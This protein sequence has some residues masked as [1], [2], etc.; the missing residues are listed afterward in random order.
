[1]SPISTWSRCYRRWVNLIAVI[2]LL[3]G[4]LAL[5]LAKP[6]AA[7]S[8][9]TI[10]GT[11][12]DTHG[13]PLGI[14]GV[15][16][17]Q[18][19]TYVGSGV[20][21][22]NGSYS[23]TFPSGTYTVYV[24]HNLTQYVD[25]CYDSGAPGNFTTNS[26]ACTPVDASASNVN[27]PPIAV[28][29]GYTISGTITD[30]N[31]TPLVG[32]HVGVQGSSPSPGTITAPDGT[33]SMA[34]LPGSYAVQFS[35]NGNYA[36]GCYD[37]GAP[38]NFTTN[39]SA[40]TLVAASASNVNLPAIAMPL[41]STISGKVTGPDGTTGLSGIIVGV[42]GSNPANGTRTAPDGTYSMTVLPGSYKVQF[43]DPSGT[44]ATGFYSTSGFVPS[45]HDATTLSV[46]PAATNINVS[47]P[48]VQISTGTT[49]HP[50]TPTRLLD[51][52][53]GNGL[54][55][56]LA[57]NT[58]ATFQVT[59]RGG[60]PSSATAVTGNVT[61]TGSTAGWAIYLGPDPIASPTSSTVN[62]SAG[63]VVAN[64]VTVALGS[65]GSMS[66]TYMS[67]AG[68]TTDLV[69]DVTGYF[70]PDTSGATYHAMTPTRLLDTRV[71]NGLSAKLAAN[72]PATFQ[73]SGRAGIPANATAVTGNLTVVDETSA[74]AVFLGPDPNPSPTSS[75][76]NFTTGDILANGLDVALSSG[77]TLSATYISTTG[78]TT[79]LVFDVT[80]YFTADTSGAKYVALAPARLLDTRSGNGLSGKLSANTPATFQVAGRGGVPANATAV[81]GNVTVVNETAAWAVFLG[82]DPIANPTSSTINFTT[83]DI[84][85]NGLTV[86]LSATGTLSATYMSTAGNTTDLVFDVT[87]Y[88][89]P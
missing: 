80:G 45:S 64:G 76:I 23:L 50:L 49:Y 59:G 29:L 20:V 42:Q 22:G 32:I 21:N 63:Q 11:V 65:T 69:F 2:A 44:H 14:I 67:T 52:R 68:N 58:P 66:A 4:S 89:T 71:A 27:L 25:G 9:Y 38:G 79:D 62:F 1:M 83:G 47:M 34:V 60:V 88:F 39:S 31:G 18:G 61:V 53:S 15:Y 57:A 82:P 36:D 73:V 33:Y 24:N 6:V 40:C 72:T 3:V 26:S 37:S 70:T 86:A 84:R 87:G 19:G 51:T 13:T 81:T 7:D 75:T 46:P 78:A 12:T 5:P 8:N 10:S 48:R 17:M 54:S 30:T 85:A 56:N 74:W 41:G 77:G 43:Q 28:P 16:A 55:G 35:G